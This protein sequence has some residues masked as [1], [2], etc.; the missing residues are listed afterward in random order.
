MYENLEEARRAFHEDMLMM[1][2][3]TEK[4]LIL[5]GPAEG[6]IGDVPLGCTSI[7]LPDSLRGVRPGSSALGGEEHLAGSLTPG[8]VEYVR[9]DDRDAMGRAIFKAAPSP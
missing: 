8:G 4:A 7:R 5:T 6:W 9:G 1:P 2:C 3:P